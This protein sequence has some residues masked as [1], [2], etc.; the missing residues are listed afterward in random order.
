MLTCVFALGVN[1]PTFD[2]W[3]WVDMV[4]KFDS[5][6]LTVADLWKQNNEHRILIPSLIA[7]ALSRVGGY[8]VVIENL[9][10]MVCGVIT[11]FVVILMLRRTLA[12]QYVYWA[13]AI[14]CLLIFSLGQA[15]TYLWG[16]QF[17]WVFVNLLFFIMVEILSRER[18]TASALAT[19]LVVAVSAS[20]SLAQGLALLPI[21]FG[22]IA[23]RRPFPRNYA[24]I[25]GLL[26]VVTAAAY[27]YHFPFNAPP[28]AYEHQVTDQFV[29]VP[30]LLVF[31]GAPIAGWSGNAG[32]IV[33]GALVSAFLAHASW[34]YVRLLRR[35]PHAAKP[36]TPWIAIALFGV[37][38][39]A[40]VAVGRA[41]LGLDLMRTERYLTLATMT[42]LGAVPLAALELQRLT[43]PSAQR[44]A[45]FYAVSCAT[46][47]GLSLI[48][49]NIVAVQFV[50][51]RH[52][53][54]VQR[55]IMILEYQRYSN[56]ALI[57]GLFP[58]PPATAAMRAYHFPGPT[59]VRPL[60]EALQ[61]YREGPFL[62]P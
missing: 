20:V 51:R 35:S 25:W 48:V 47:L 53:L 49:E 11:L 62:R 58:F 55:R 56:D 7:L 26:S 38:G 30:A 24:L 17:A 40:M 37:L 33:A 18:L 60:I 3:R 61:H 5:S 12:G 23:V 44:R 42:W 15:E 13:F 8:D 10:C 36:W 29:R 34:M 27:F 32:S 43:S 28:Y 22:M 57:D 39:G 54:M 59:Q 1:V 41:G 21:G 9:F 4:L 46:I 6:R 50:Q 31:L 52:A 2:D 16:F 14:E 45:M 19:A